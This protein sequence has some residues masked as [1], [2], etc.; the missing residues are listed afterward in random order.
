M[1]FTSRLKAKEFD[2]M[3][4]NYKVQS[5]TTTL[6]SLLSTPVAKEF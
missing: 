1:N 3:L 4:V 6:T 2:P 5:S